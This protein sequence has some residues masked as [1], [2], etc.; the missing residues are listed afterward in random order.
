VTSALELD[1]KDELVPATT[2][3]EHGLR[4][5]GYRPAVAVDANALISD[6]IYRWRKG[7]SLVPLLAEQNTITLVTAAHIDEKVYAGLPE[8]CANTHADLDAAAEVYETRHRPLLRLVS[9]GDLML[10][11]ERV[12]AVALDDPEDVPL[13]Q[14]GVLLA[15][16]LV[17][18]RDKHLLGAGLGVREWADALLKLKALIELEH[19]AWGV[20]DGVVITG[21]LTFCG[22]RGLIRALVC[23]ELAL[24]LALGVAL[25]LG[26]FYREE[27]ASSATRLKDR[28]GPV[29]ERAMDGMSV[30]VERW[31]AAVGRVRPTLVRPQPTATLEAT[32]A[33]M[34]L[35]SPGPLSAATIHSRLPYP[36]HVTPEDQ[37][38]SVLREQPAFELVRGLGWMLG[39]RALAPPPR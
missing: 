11:D 35:P 28:A 9:V 10:H 29:V 21:G 30:A 7:F 5:R 4:P 1:R 24:G 26:I 31:E 36:W 3:G 8:A 14:L 27:L 2:P 19:A 39:H 20:A 38:R 33:R 23:S 34:L 18:T 25:G 22:V 12:G 37:L 32:V 15:P 17:L 6:A 13:A 16:A